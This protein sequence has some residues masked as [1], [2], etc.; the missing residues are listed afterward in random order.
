MTSS[1]RN[2]HELA[3][4]YQLFP[5]PT[6]TGTPA[7][8]RRP[9]DSALAASSPASRTAARTAAVVS[10][11]VESDCQNNSSTS[12]STSSTSPLH[13][14]R[15]LPSRSIDRKNPPSPLHSL[16]ALPSSGAAAGARSNPNSN[17][18]LS[19]TAQI[20]L[21][22]S[23][24]FPLPPASHPYPSPAA[25]P[26]ASAPVPPPASRAVCYTPAEPSRDQQPRSPRERLDD[27]L[28]Q[29]AA[30]C[31]PKEPSMGDRSALPPPSPIEPPSKA[32]WPGVLPRTPNHIAM[33]SARAAMPVPRNSSID[34]AISSISQ[35]SNKS[36]PREPSSPSPADY[37]ALLAAAG[38]PEAAIQHLLKEK[39]SSSSQNAQLWRLVDKQRT[40]ILGLNKDLEAAL[41][42]KERY[43]K[44]LKEHLARVSESPA[45]SEATEDPASRS[46]SVNDIVTGGLRDSSATLILNVDDS[47]G[48]SPVDT[49]QMAQQSIA[50]SSPAHR[51]APLHLQAEDR[52]KKSLRTLVEHE[53]QADDAA[54]PQPAPSKVP[55][56]SPSSPRKSIE[57][58]SPRSFT[59]R[60]TT[61]T[62]QP[63]L[64]GPSI[65]VVNASPRGES[66]MQLPRKLPP[67]SLNLTQPS[68]A[69]AHL[70]HA[71]PDDVSGSDYDDI[72]EV[73]EIPA[74][75][76]GRRKTREEDDR[77]RE[78]TAIKEK[79]ARSRSKKEKSAKGVPKAREAVEMK[80]AVPISPP[81]SYRS[82]SASDP[83]SLA[84]MLSKQL[85]MSP[86]ISPGLPMSPRPGDRP[87]NSPPPRLPRNGS[88]LNPMASPPL[89][90]RPGFPGLPLSPRAPRYTIPFPPNTPMSMASPALARNEP[91]LLSPR[92]PV[93]ARS[94]LSAPQENVAKTPTVERSTTIYQGFVS[95]EYPNLLL[96]PNA[97]PSI[98]VKVCS[99]RLKPS[100]ASFIAG[101]SDTPPVF[102]LGIF[103]RSNR[104]ELWRVEKDVMS[105]P[106]LDHSLRM[107][108]N[109][110]G[111][112]PEGSIFTG[113]APVRVDARRVALDQYFDAILNTQLDDKAG[114]VVCQYLSSDA[115]EPHADDI[116][117]MADAKVNEGQSNAG[118]KVTGKK[119]GY[120][121]KRGKNFGGW[122]ARFFQ[123]DGPILRYYDSPGGAHLGTIKLLNSQ[124]GK[125]SQSSHSPAREETN[126]DNDNQ[127]RH[128]FLILEPKKKDSSS[129]VR[130]VL[131]AESDV[132]RD[133]WVEALLQY[134]HHLSSDDEPQHQKKG[135]AGKIA[136]LQAK[137]KMGGL[138]KKSSR[139]KNG[140]EEEEDSST[141]MGLS[142]ED[143]N[144]SPT[145]LG[146]SYEDTLQAETPSRVSQNT[147][148]PPANASTF[149][150][151]LSAAPQSTKQISGPT[152]AV[153]IQDAGL[154]G[155]RS[156]S[157]EK[158]KSKKRSIW[159][160]GYKGRTSSDSPGPGQTDSTY[161]GAPPRAVFGAPLAEVAMF[162]R[163]V[164]INVFLPAVVYRCIEYLDAKDA[165][166]E[167][168][169]FRLSG[170]NVVIKGLRERF[171][172][173][174]DVN[175]LAEDHY[176]DV[177]AVASLLKMYLRELPSTVL[178]RD[179]HLDFLKVLELDDADSKI[180]ALN[181]L[182]HKLPP[183]N[184]ALLR[185]LSAFLI[186]VVTNS[187]VNKMNVRN[188]GIVFSPTLNIP[189]PVFAMFLTEF[190][191]IFTEEVDEN[192][193]PL[194]VSASP[195][196][197]PEDI[198][199]PRRQMFQELPTPS[200]N[201]SSFPS[202]HHQHN[203]NPPADLRSPRR[204]M[205]QELPTPSYNQP[206][207]PINPNVPYRQ[208]QNGFGQIPEN[209][210][211]F[212][213]MQP[214]YP[215][216]NYHHGS[217]SF[218][219][220]A[221]HPMAQ[222][223]QEY[224]S[225]NGAL[226]SG[227][228]S[229]G[230]GDLPA[231]S[232][233]RR[234]ESSML[235]MGMGQK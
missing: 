102:T 116:P 58:P 138:G 229:S 81:S 224:A 19:P 184:W 15:H 104:R 14:R 173:E 35:T 2:T 113:H 199:S 28:A 137:I 74:F 78:Q 39:R 54:V 44:T 118:S 231:N 205:F 227:G 150:N 100:R 232:K 94:L 132:E 176:F 66:S 73:D 93:V 151:H 159:G 34:S 77:E 169:L 110:T 71:E 121:T 189:A 23:T 60:R 129:L 122:K 82:S 168:G 166:S 203:N 158:I 22:N 33:A 125:Q 196:L 152:N 221:T 4:E 172:T 157:D 1:L 85:V 10:S 192:H 133:E 191:R 179:L 149:V 234:R 225:L 29:E 145:L 120:L 177:H 230:L 193:S 194:D 31:A 98:D 197:T 200:Y 128:A 153:P 182:V 12:I 89:S 9:S 161:G 70:H 208:A 103:S 228:P 163:P 108:S 47:P 187:A 185:V 119:E 141:L 198:R 210:T 127:Y 217:S 144:D 201:Q 190:D 114:L 43:R 24:A 186:N 30:H 76:R 112:L 124:I 25:A 36:S 202:H 109:F 55:P 211:G 46:Q 123:M 204:Q 226:V 20:G 92:A 183:A 61:P 5:A 40:M 206:N 214:A 147:P 233:A 91:G 155:N 134:V 111:R 42:D 75:E 175:F 222:A 99:S 37:A 107:S 79:E 45:P 6:S 181:I 87:L 195:P 178:T 27:L 146:L 69:S 8:S 209:D 97:L 53:V 95:D 18:A 207:F 16:G 162:A 65:N 136:G 83:E 62:L 90:P 216:N 41:K 164:G 3:H 48:S 143:D 49:P 165:A 167:E 88:N 140:A 115:L 180:L 86:P 213:P 126:D 21:F 84:S 96:P 56:L 218:G 63:A 17:L 131:C 52:G 26:A 170:S 174:G 130:H 148:S 51:P 57:I 13:A 215:P 142:Y 212:I 223:S 156:N 171:N 32:P 105:L 7:V 38:S 188:V 80:Q 219:R 160:F 72:L 135:S 154:W 64:Q 117:L 101:M 139:E 106:S 50:S 59:A 220:S 235:S 68:R 67:P 11:P